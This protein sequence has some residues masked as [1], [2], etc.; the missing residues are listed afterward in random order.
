MIFY[1]VKHI[2][3]GEYMPAKMFRTRSAGFTWWEPGDEHLGGYTAAPRLWVEK[4]GASRALH[5]WI[6]GRLN[7]KLGL[8]AG[9]NR[10]NGDLQV[11]RISLQEISDGS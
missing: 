10:K 4:S 5:R 6:H 7:S 9:S 11:V 2:A 8:L 3:T 1:A